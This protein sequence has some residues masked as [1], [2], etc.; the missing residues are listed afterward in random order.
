MKVHLSF[1]EFNN[2]ID[3]LSNTFDWDAAAYALGGIIDPHF[4]KSSVTSTS[5]RYVI[6]PQRKNDND[7]LLPKVDRPW[8]LRINEIFEAAA[9]EME[10]NKRKELYDEW[11]EITQDQCIKI[12]LPLREV[13][14]GVQNR[15]GNIHLTRY[16]GLGRDVFHNID[17]IYIKDNQ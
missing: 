11:Q 15:F 6:N 3:K 1:I 5:F 17:E 16:L 10:R 12:Y 8:E 2:M 14:L 4:G 9:S 7:R 13:V